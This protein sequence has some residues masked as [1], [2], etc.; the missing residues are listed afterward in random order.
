MQVAVFDTY[1]PKKEGGLMHF[2]ILVDD[3]QKHD[4]ERVFSFG[5]TYLASKGQAG[6]CISTDECQFCHIEVAPLHVMK[7]IQNQGYFIVEMQG[8]G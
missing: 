2:D 1:V 4:K 8:C 6:Q 5:K 3:A 7:A